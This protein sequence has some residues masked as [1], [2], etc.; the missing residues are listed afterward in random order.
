MDTDRAVTELLAG[1][2][3]PGLYRWPVAGTADTTAA[4]SRAAGEGV[5][6]F[7]LD[8]ARIAG[9]D[10]LL[11]ACADAFDLPE[12]F[13]A[14]WDALEDSLTDLSWAPS[15]RGYLVVYDGWERLADAD[16][17]SFRTVLDVFAEAVA[18]W[19]DTATPMSVLLPA[20]LDGTPVPAGLPVLE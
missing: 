13:G 9:K 10:G 3:P 5:R 11:R 17:G 19:R 14:N 8:G 20:E 7:H 12:W 6:A 18:S 2:R 1:R 15:R 4:L 16:E